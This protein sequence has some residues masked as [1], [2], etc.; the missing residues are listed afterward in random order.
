MN[1][2]NLTW[3]CMFSPN[4]TDC[5][6]IYTMNPSSVQ[7]SVAVIQH[8]WT[9]APC[10]VVLQKTHLIHRGSLFALRAFA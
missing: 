6:I 7:F 3:F 10:R 4:G 9:P 5:R 8:H 1:A 2:M